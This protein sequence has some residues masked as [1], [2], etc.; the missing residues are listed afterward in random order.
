MNKLKIST[1][2]LWYVFVNDVSTTVDGILHPKRDTETLTIRRNSPKRGRMEM[3]ETRQKDPV[4]CCNCK[5]ILKVLV[6]I[7]SGHDEFYKTSTIR[8]TMD[9]WC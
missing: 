7:K 1:I 5:E 3:E 6:N 4:F 9:G 8:L 2:L